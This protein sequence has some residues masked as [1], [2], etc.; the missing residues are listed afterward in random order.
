M[1]MNNNNRTEIA[2]DAGSVETL[3]GSLASLWDLLGA[4]NEA[5]GVLAEQWQG[6]SDI[7]AAS[8]ESQTM[9]AETFAASNESILSALDSEQT[10]MI[11]A[12]ALI[13]QVGL[14]WEL[15]S[16]KT[17]LGGGAA[18][19]TARIFASSMTSITDGMNAALAM[20]AKLTMII[21]ASANR[22]ILA[23][24]KDIAT[25]K[26][27]AWTVKERFESWV[28]PIQKSSAVLRTLGSALG[29]S[30]HLR[31]MSSGLIDAAEDLGLYNFVT[32]LAISLQ[33]KK[34]KEDQESVV[35]QGAL[36]V[37]TQAQTGAT[38]V[39]TAATKAFSTAIKANP[40]GLLITGISIL[41][42]LL[43]AFRDNVEEDTDSLDENSDSMRRNVSGTQH[44][45]EKT[46]ELTDAYYSNRDARADAFRDLSVNAEVVGSLAA[47]FDE[48]ANKENRSVAEKSE[49]ARLTAQLNELLPELNLSYD[50]QADK[51]EGSTKEIKSY[52]EAYRE[53]LYVEQVASAHINAL[54]DELN[55]KKQLSDATKEEAAQKEKVGRLEAEYGHLLDENGKKK[56]W[57]GE[58]DIKHADLLI[59]EKKTLAELEE[60]VGRLDKAFNTA[61]SEKEFFAGILVNTDAVK[62]AVAELGVEIPAHIQ[63]GIEEGAYGLNLAKEDIRKILDFE[64]TAALATGSG[65]MIMENL[66]VSMEEGAMGPAEAFS[67][68]QAYIEFQSMYDSF[69]ESGQAVMDIYATQM[70]DGSMKPAQA[71]ELVKEYAMLEAQGLTSALGEEAG[72]SIESMHEKALEKINASETGTAF[73][74]RAYGDKYAQG[75]EENSGKSKTAV[76]NLVAGNTTVG[77]GAISSPVTGASVLGIATVD[78]EVAGM[79]ADA[80]KLYKVIRRLCK[81]TVYEGQSELESNSPSKRFA[82]EVGK[83][84]P[85]GIALGVADNADLVEQSIGSMLDINLGSE[86]KRLDFSAMKKEFE[87]A[88]MYDRSRASA[89]AYTGL[90]T[91]MMESGAGISPINLETTVISELDGREIARGTARFM[92][93]E[94]GNIALRKER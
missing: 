25:V 92:D 26:D 63:Q 74:G 56:T 70:L 48:L 4:S 10:A 5:I 44:L 85:Q 18:Q 14:Q 66:R 42:S 73:V 58:E 34:K 87:T 21:P 54:I 24:G 71:L 80:W 51:L 22:V 17:V 65:A 67:Q 36:T 75:I 29:L 94:L 81:N 43:P 9:L 15:L 82:R 90:N 86:I 84:I 45:I 33:A 2:L 93:K 12:K 23:L 38:V 72:V 40:I 68:A 46:K 88:V 55:L 6:L 27:P 1:S 57:L 60:E 61:S 37:A 52:I 69:G 20:G 31:E 39:G 47:R 50:E 28:G 79:E 76:I 64:E 49:L 91:F 19:Q 78:G 62:S 32:K 89:S 41:L 3:S 8:G 7:M 53:K 30:K 35:A 77:Q 13:G 59:T 11:M 16:G 83:P